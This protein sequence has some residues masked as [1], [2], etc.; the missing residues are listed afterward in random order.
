[1]ICPKCS[2]RSLIR[3]QYLRKRD[4]YPKKVEFCIT[5]GCG[6]RFDHTPE[7]PSI[8]KLNKEREEKQGQQLLFF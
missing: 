4:G 2:K 6:Y 3:K 5:K 8:A 1:M 7:A